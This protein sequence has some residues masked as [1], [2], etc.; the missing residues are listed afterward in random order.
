MESSCPHCKADLLYERDGKTYS[1][2]TGV[3]IST[4]FD[5][6]LFWLC[7]RCMG[8]WHRFPPASELH[9]RAA[10]EMEKYGRWDSTGKPRHTRKL[11]S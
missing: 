4:I 11:A 5:G 10:V 2:V 6:I 8:V 9:A 3:E 1:H 7:P